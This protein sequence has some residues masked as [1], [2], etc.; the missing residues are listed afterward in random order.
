MSVHTNEKKKITPA[1]LKEKKA[2]GE[3]I[4]M[5][6]A[7]DYSTAS[8][9][10]NAGIDTILVGDS[11][12]QVVLG[13]DSTVPV[14]M[15]DMLHHCKAVR[16][17]TKY[18]FL[19]ADM[20]FLSYQVSIE[21]AK[22]NAGR[23]AKESGCDAVKL[24][25]GIEMAETIRSI[26]KMGIPVVGHIGFTPQSAGA[27]EGIVQGKTI[28]NAQYQLD[29]AKALEQAGACMIVLEC[30]P[31]LLAEVIT[32]AV[33]VPTIGIGAG[34]EC[35]GQVLVVND[36][37]GLFQKFV[38]KFV[39]QYAKLYPLVEEAV[40][41]YIAEVEGGQFPKQEHTFKIDEA[42]IAKLKK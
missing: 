32:K 20:P 29:S 24:E 35:D 21:D 27:L 33:K 25:G 26:V 14:T 28:E 31:A 42:V 22:R 6:T 1:F 10:D 15:E 30:I 34:A 37:L 9:M 4:T 36:M 12:G 19:I 7:Y 13:Y 8:I 17:G 39:K 38:P 3:R 41:S 5:L 2:K 23:F 40:K 16:R 11:L 18:A